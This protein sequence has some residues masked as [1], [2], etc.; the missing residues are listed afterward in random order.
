MVKVDG[1]AQPPQS[2]E[3]DGT[4]EIIDVSID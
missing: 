1:T 3:V 4:R 2:F